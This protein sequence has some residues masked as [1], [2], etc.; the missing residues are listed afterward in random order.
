LGER[1]TIR[2]KCYD[3]SDLYRWIITKSNKILL[4][5]RKEIIEEEKQV[6]IQEYKNLPKVFIPNI[7]TR[8]KLIQIYLNFQQRIVLDLL[9]SDYIDIT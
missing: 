3:V 7:L 1:I 2:N 4:S 5:T 8:N 6:L 9:N